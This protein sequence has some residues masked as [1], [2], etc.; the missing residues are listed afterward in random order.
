MKEHHRVLLQA[1]TYKCLPDYHMKG[2]LQ[3]YTKNRLKCSSFVHEAKK[4]KKQHALV[5]DMPVTPH[6]LCMADITN[7]FAIDLSAVAICT[8]V[9]HLEQ[10][11]NDDNTKR[12][13]TLAVICEQYPPEAWTHVYTGGSATTVIQNGGVG[14]AIYLPNDS[15]KQPVQ[16]QED[17]T[18]TTK[19]RVRGIDESH[20][21]SC[22]LCI[23]HRNAVYKFYKP[24]PTTN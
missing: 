11:T 16:Q 9:P 5:L 7:I 12:T 3:S 19:H 1:H 8:K 13:Q 20:L 24:W 21:S 15:K 22:G 23:S 17:T 4:L 18:A 2:K 6:L 14:I 10:G